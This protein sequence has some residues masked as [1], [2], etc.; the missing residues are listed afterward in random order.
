MRSGPGCQWSTVNTRGRSRMS[1]D[2]PATK[3]RSGTIKG[4]ET[5]GH[6]VQE[7]LYLACDLMNVC[8]SFAL[9][10]YNH[11]VSF[12]LGM[13]CDLL[14]A[15]FSTNH[16][17]SKSTSD[18]VASSRSL[19][20]HHPLPTASQ[21]GPPSNDTSFSPF[22]TFS[23]PIVLSNSVPFPE[24]RPPSNASHHSV[25]Y[26]IFLSRSLAAVDL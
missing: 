6:T 21:R 19:V 9:Y 18:V 4:L 13:S 1:S 25:S 2:K 22:R 10:V 8:T 5:R 15:V 20:N 16:H 14:T 11:G 17:S 23:A 12:F 7:S 3:G 24:S 26:S